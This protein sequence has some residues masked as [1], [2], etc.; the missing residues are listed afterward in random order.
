M[1]KTIENITE[2]QLISLAT[3][4]GKQL[5]GSEIILLSGDLGAGKTVF[6]KALAKGYGVQQYVTSPTFTLLNIYDTHRGRFLHL[7]LYRLEDP[8]EVAY[9]GIEEYY[10]EALIAIEWPE[11]LP[12]V[13]DHFMFIQ[14]LAIDGEHRTLEL[15][16]KGTAEEEMLKEMERIAYLGT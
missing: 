5:Q 8:N 10:D 4:V 1:K 7:D 3:T 11:R 9:L 16:A 2:E 14:I 6:A 15:E 13:P 12:E